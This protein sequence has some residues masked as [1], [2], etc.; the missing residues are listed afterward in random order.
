MHFSKKSGRMS[1]AGPEN[2][3]L[4]SHCSVRSQRILNCF[5]PNFKLKYED[6][7]YIKIDRV[8]TEVFN[9][10]QIER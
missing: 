9:L 4:D 8:N 5:M 3:A 10:H 2:L 6:L 1:S 7:D